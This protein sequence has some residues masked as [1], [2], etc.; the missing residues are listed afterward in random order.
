MAVKD[1]IQSIKNNVANAY[2]KL[3][4][5]GATIPE[6]KNI[7]NLAS[8]IDTVTSGGS[9][10]GT[11]YIT[12][13]GTYDVAQYA[14]ADVSVSVPTEPIEPPILTTKTIT[15]NGTYNASD[16]NADGYSSVTVNVAS[17]GER[18]TNET[19]YEMKR[20]DYLRLQQGLIGFLDI[21]TEEEYLE[22][23]TYVNSTIETIMGVAF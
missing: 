23:Q 6:K 1:T 5:K 10:E 9:V 20:E 16:D 14:N 7:E 17:G 21:P 13:N 15:E 22:Q 19:L 4:G 11:I 8:T 3:Q 2:T 12:T 18:D